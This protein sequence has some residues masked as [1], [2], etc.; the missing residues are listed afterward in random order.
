MIYSTRAKELFAKQ[1][2]Q[3]TANLKDAALFNLRADYESRTEEE[4]YNFAEEAFYQSIVAEINV[5]VTHFERMKYGT[6]QEETE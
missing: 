2:I 4:G 3:I 1:L 6:G 5:R